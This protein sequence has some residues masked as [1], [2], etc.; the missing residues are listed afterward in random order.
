LSKD[1]T[2]IRVDGA[3]VEEFGRK[4]FATRF[5]SGAV[6]VKLVDVRDDSGKSISAIEFGQ[7]MELSILAQ[8][9]MACQRL[10]VAFYLKD[11]NRLEVLGTNSDY[12]HQPVA[13]VKAGETLVYRYRFQALVKQGV[14]TV[15]VILAAGPDVQEYYDWIEDALSFEVVCPEQKRYAL[16]S[17]PVQLTVVRSGD[18]VVEG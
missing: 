11:R 8:A 10:T 12:E 9:S 3:S 17:P 18:L 14:Y 4:R 6:G 2:W 1:D 7:Y 16:Y 5:G 15:T 13:D